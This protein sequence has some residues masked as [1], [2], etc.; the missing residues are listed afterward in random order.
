M[1]CFYR[2]L[3]HN[4]LHASVS[5]LSYQVV[6]FNCY[7]GHEKNMIGK[8][9]NYEKFQNINQKPVWTVIETGISVG[10]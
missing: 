2:Q 3:I 8:C 10:I 1:V 7:L 4:K 5:S 6:K 9:V